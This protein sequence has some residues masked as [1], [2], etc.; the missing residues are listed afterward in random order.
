[1]SKLAI[2]AEVIEGAGLFERRIVEPKGRDAQALRALV[3][4]G[5]KGITS[6]DVGGWAVRL[7]HYVFKLRT[8]YGLVI[9]TVE[10]R[11]GGEFPGH[12]G[13]YFLRSNVRIL[14]DGERLVSEGRAA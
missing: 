7:S 6:Q 11:H 1:M 9:E 13:R 2:R 4:A 3:E 8:V 5:P 14:D 12:H 10:E